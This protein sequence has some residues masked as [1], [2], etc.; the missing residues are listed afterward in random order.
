MSLSFFY[1]I[2]YISKIIYIKM[3]RNIITKLYE[4]VMTQPST[5]PSPTTVPTTPTR[6]ETPPAPARPGRPVPDREPRPE[7]TERPI[8][9]SFGEVMGK[10]KNSLDQERGTKLAMGIISRLRKLKNLPIA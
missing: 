7:E 9:K 3:G 6:P 2:R 1:L 8:A 10:M 4:F 5:K